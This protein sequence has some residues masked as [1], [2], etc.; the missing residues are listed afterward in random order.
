MKAVVIGNGIAGIEAALTIRGRE[1]DWD[2]T[3]VSE[4]SDHFFSRTALMWVVTGQLSHRCIEP[5]DRDL[6][7]QDDSASEV[8][9][10]DEAL[11][12]LNQSAVSRISFHSML[13]KPATAP[14]GSP[15]D[16]RVRGGSA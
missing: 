6:Y 12:M 5:H 4:E 14:T 3:I 9:V 15:S 2:V 8:F 1:P 16:L 13:Q 7:E 11:P 10:V